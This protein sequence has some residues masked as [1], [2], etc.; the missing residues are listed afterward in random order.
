MRFSEKQMTNLTITQLIVENLKRTEKTEL[1]F[2]E[3]IRLI[4]ANI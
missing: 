1:L 2:T 4:F 3:Q